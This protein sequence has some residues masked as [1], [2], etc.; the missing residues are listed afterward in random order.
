MPYLQEVSGFEASVITGAAL[1]AAVLPA[2]GYLLFDAVRRRGDVVRTG[3]YGVLN[4]SDEDCNVSGSFRKISAQQ[5]EGVRSSFR[6]AWV[7]PITRQQES[8]KKS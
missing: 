4:Y 7:E 6:A 5:S 3:F 2:A 1:Y 8:N